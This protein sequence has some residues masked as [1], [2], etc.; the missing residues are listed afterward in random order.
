MNK[1]IDN[2]DKEHKDI[3]IV[4]KPNRAKLR[5]LPLTE[6]LAYRDAV[7]L[8]YSHFDNLAKSNAG[9]YDEIKA[10][11]YNDAAKK[12]GE[13]QRLLMVVFEIIKEKVD[14]I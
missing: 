6:L 14:E 12:A 4:L 9:E 3:K 13:Y 7:Q 1:K 2:P 10:A 5:E 11:D 8:V